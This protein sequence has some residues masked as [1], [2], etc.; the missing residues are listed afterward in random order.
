MASAIRWRHDDG[1]VPVTFAAD[2]PGAIV[3]PARNYGYGAAK[4]QPRAWCLHTPEEPADDVPSTPEYLHNTDRLAS[5]HYFVSYH[6]LV[7]QC[8]PE[9]EG[10]Y[11]NAVEGKPYPPWASG[12]NLN[13]ETLSIEIEGKAATIAQTM[14]RGSPQWRALVALMAHR[15]KALGFPVDRTFGHKVVSVLRSDPGNLD[16]A[17]L[18]EDVKGD[19]DMTPDEVRQVIRE[20][21]GAGKDWGGVPGDTYNAWLNRAIRA[22]LTEQGSAGIDFDK[23]ATAVA[24][25]LAARLKD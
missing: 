24:D 2:Y 5:V 20:E 21:L 17:A 16:I 1:G 25:K 13:L 6:G 18:I 19:D 4:C 11:A 15:C 12:R 22:A 8:V 9:S 23:L 7:F 10:P 14:P 3:V